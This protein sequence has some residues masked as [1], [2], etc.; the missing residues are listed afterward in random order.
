MAPAVLSPALSHRDRD[1]CRN[2][3]LDGT[4]LELGSFLFIGVDDKTVSQEFLLTSK[5]GGPLQW[6]AGFNYYRNEDL[7]DVDIS[8]DGSLPFGLTPRQHYAWY[9]HGGGRQLMDEIYDSLG[10]VGIPCGNTGGQMFG[11]FRKELK[12][13]EDF[14]GVKM[15]VAGFGGR[16]LQKLGVIPQQIAGGEIYQALEKGTIDAC[17]W[18]GP[19]DDE[20]LGLHK[21]AKYYYYTGWWEGSAT[22]HI[23]IGLDKWESLPKSYQAVIQTAAAEAHNWQHSRYD[24]LNPAALKRL[25]GAGLELKRFPDDIMDASFKAAVELYDE[26]SAT[27][28]EFKKVYEHVKAYRRE[29]LSWYQVA[30]FTYDTFMLIQ[31]QKKT[32]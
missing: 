2:E 4:G 3:D 28:P 6:T 8:F 15:R 11:W 17:E 29:W 10:V 26:I 22:G 13:V 14:K 20:K 19:Y 27:N 21:V 7:W 32:L 31:Y 24:H 9:N 18:V 25:I 12:T 30:D 5:P 23:F 16:V 1:E